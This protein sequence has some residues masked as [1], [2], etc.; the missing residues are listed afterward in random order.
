VLYSAGHWSIHM[1]QPSYMLPD[2]FH[3]IVTALAPAAGVH[4]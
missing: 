4:L 1:V 2:T 3:V